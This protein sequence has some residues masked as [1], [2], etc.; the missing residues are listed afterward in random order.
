MRY[1]FRRLYYASE[2]R[3]ILG[4]RGGVRGFFLVFLG[5]CAKQLAM[6][7]LRLYTCIRARRTAKELSQRKFK[8]LSEGAK[9]EHPSSSRSLICSKDSKEHFQCLLGENL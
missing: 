6:H 5:A 1:L 7:G 8:G 4:H 9:N 2:E 3:F